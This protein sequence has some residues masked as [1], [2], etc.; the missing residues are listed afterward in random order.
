MLFVDWEMAFDKLSRAGLTHA[1]V[2][3]GVPPDVIKVIEGLYAIAPLR[4][5]EGGI[6]SEERRRESGIRQG[7]PLSPYLFVNFHDRL[8]P[9][10][11]TRLRSGHRRSYPHAF[12]S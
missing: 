7:C 6:L 2:R 4:V 8:T 9:R 3:I 11:S 12:S 5:R 10:S 1:L